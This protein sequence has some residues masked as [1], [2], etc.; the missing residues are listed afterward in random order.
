MIAVNNY[1][2]LLTGHEFYFLVLNITISY[3]NYDS[4]QMHAKYCAYGCKQQYK[5]RGGVLQSY[6]SYPTSF[7]YYKCESC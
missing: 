6:K 7:L 3:H 1:I 2:V 4:V 5:D